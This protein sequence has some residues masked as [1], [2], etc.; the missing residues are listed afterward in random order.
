[1]ILGGDILLAVDGLPVVTLEGHQQVQD[2]L[3]RLREGDVVAME[4]LRAGRRVTIEH[5]HQHLRERARH[6]REVS[7]RRAAVQAAS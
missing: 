4:V 1:M 3:G 2:R 7:V 6:M 5:R